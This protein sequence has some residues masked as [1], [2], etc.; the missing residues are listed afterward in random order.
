MQLC[1]VD[2]TVFLSSMRLVVSESG[3]APLLLRSL[4]SGVFGALV[5]D[6]QKKVTLVSRFFWWEPSL[7]FLMRD[8]M[9]YLISLA[10][11]LQYSG[12]LLPICLQSQS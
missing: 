7:S 1:L 5:G 12:L 8:F 10:I 2:L 6:G 9:K 3:W 4:V 11:A